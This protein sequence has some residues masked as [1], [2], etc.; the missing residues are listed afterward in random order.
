M[1]N[2]LLFA[3]PGMA[4]QASRKLRDIP[5][6]VFS[7]P[8]F[9]ELSELAGTR[10]YDVWIVAVR[11]LSSQG[12]A[13]ED[14]VRATGATPVVLVVPPEEADGLA[15]DLVKFSGAYL[16]RE[17]ATAEELALVVQRAAEEKRLR[18]EL[19]FLQGESSADIGP[20]SIITRS[21]LM[22]Q[23]LDR[24]KAVAPTEATVLLQGETG[25]GKEL[26]AR[27]IHALSQRKERPFIAVNC[28][29]LPDTLIESE[30]F[31]HERGAFTGASSRRIGKLEDTRGGTVF[32]DEVETM[33]PA[34]Q[35]RLLRVLQDRRVQRLG[36]NIEIPV[37]FRLI[38]AANED[39]S[40]L[41]QAGRFRRDLLYRLMVVPLHLPPLRERKE[42]I[43]LLAVHFLQR[44]R[45]RGRRYVKGISPRA[46]GQL[47]G[48]PW[49]GNVRE[50]EN[51]IERAVILASDEEID[52]FGLWE[53]GEGVDPSAAAPEDRGFVP[54]V[55]L[56]AYKVSV[57]RDAERKY[58]I[59]LLQHTGGRIG[60]AARFAGL[61]PRA[62]YE[63]MRYH[64][65]RKEDFRA[66][67]SQIPIGT[68]SGITFQ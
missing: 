60:V 12:Q 57:W 41:V 40:H 55:T 35:I 45:V 47:M 51:V 23:V 52:D 48:Y 43:G 67:D 36:S 61:S 13:V 18:D 24:L 54:G 42:D 44:A 26:L 32:L 68:K 15:G 17:N 29:A 22:Q 65:L 7:T 50:L 9:P 8:E 4:G 37:D 64:G 3:P 19:R 14:L 34:L 53:P 16:V 56:R 49:P 58:L 63:K 66:P 38:A 1:L 25:T 31:G 28:G 6:Q 10:V 11:Q 62:L 46:M 33:S 2:V 20:G 21:G 59:S 30:L 5:A 27:L 39:L